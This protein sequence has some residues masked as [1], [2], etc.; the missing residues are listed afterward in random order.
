MDDKQT[1]SM[2]AKVIGTGA[3]LAAAFLVNQVLN[4]AWKAKTGHKPPRADDPGDA[5]LSEI[6][7]AAAL[8]GA[9]VSMARV[10]ATRGTAKFAAKTS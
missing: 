5:G 1:Q 3:A 7:A 2:V 8:T 6:V 4:Q 10:L 9:L